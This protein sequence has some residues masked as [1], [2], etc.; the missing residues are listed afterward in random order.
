MDVQ[1]ALLTGEQAGPLVPDLVDLYAAV[2]SAPPYEE[3]PEQVGEFATKIRNELERPGF[4]QTCA[5]L[6]GQLIGAAYGWT[7]EAGS[8]WSNA[9]NDPPAEILNAP[10]FAIMEWIVEL[11]HRGRHIGETVIRMLLADRTESWATLA[12]DPRSA[13]RGMYERAGW[14]QVG[15]SKLPWGTAMDVLVLPLTGRQRS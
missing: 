13:A 15:R 14:R 11:E 4:R 8:W 7:M 2:Y 3:G 1:Y 9:E 6:D 12:S 5:F 10:K